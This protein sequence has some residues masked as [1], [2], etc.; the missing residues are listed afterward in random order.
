MPKG[1]KNNKKSKTGTQSDAN[2]RKRKSV[3]NGGTV[4]QGDAVAIQQINEA[5]T[6][7]PRIGK[8]NDKNNREINKVN[9][10]IERQIQGANNNAQPDRDIDAFKVKKVTRAKFDVKAKDK[11]NVIISKDQSYKK[12]D[13]I[14]EN[15]TAFQSS[16]PIEGN[17]EDDS[18]QVEVDTTEYDDEVWEDGE[19]NSDSESISSEEDAHARSEFDDSE[20]AFNPRSNNDPGAMMSMFQEVVSKQM[21][22]ER[23]KLKKEYLELEK[24]KAEH[25]KFLE[26]QKRT[27]TPSEATPNK[28]KH[29]NVMAKSPS[30]TTIYAP[31]IARSSQTSGN[32]IDKSNTGQNGNDFMQKINDFVDQMRIQHD[33][34]T[35]KEKGN[36][37]PIR[38][39]QQKVNDEDEPQPGTSHDSRHEARSLA[40]KMVLE[41]E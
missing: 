31:A 33:S 19:I 22:E 10:T 4:V 1:N 9:D 6:K 39:V 23:E 3:E 37:S 28:G 41:A 35:E 32:G 5:T 30:D 25:Y 40:D 36:R 7:K 29:F 20:I 12:R 34:E 13:S 21:K 15:T 27:V 11:R 18:V 38:E 16:E 8:R 26:N 17:R 14:V 2:K 24:L